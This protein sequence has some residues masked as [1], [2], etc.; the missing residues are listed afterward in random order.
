MLGNF[1]YYKEPQNKINK[2]YM[3]SCMAGA[4]MTFSEFG[5][6]QASDYRTA[7]L[8]MKAGSFWT[9]SLPFL[10]HF[11]LVFTGKWRTIKR[12][13]LYIT[14]IYLPA[15][16]IALIDL[17]TNWL[18][19]GMEYK[20][21]GWRYVVAESPVTYVVYLWVVV[22]LLLSMSLCVRYYFQ[23]TDFIQKKRAKYVL[24][25]FSFY[26][27]SSLVTDSVFPALNI[28][29]PE[30]TSLAFLAEAAFIGYAVWRYKL[31]VLSPATAAESIVSTMAD[32]L[33]L[34]GPDGTIQRVNRA[35][36]EFLGYREDE[37]IGQ[38]F[39]VVIAQ[40]ESEI[41]KY[42]GAIRNRL[43]YIGYVQDFELRLS[44]VDGA[45]ISVSLSISPVYSEHGDLFGVTYIFRDLTARKKYERRLREAKEA[46]EAANRAKST[47]LAN[48]SHELRT[49]LNAI[50]GYSELLQ[51]EAA[52]CGYGE[53]EPDLEKICLA[54]RHLLALISDILDV[55]KIEAGKMELYLETFEARRL[56]DN[57]VTTVQP[58]VAQNDNVLETRYDDDLGAINADLTK[59]RQILFNL[60]SNAAKF[61]E[62]GTITLTVTREEEGE[63]AQ[64]CFRVADTGIGM[65]AEQIAHL[66]RAFSQGDDSTTRKYGGTGLGLAISYHY[67]QMMGGDIAVES[68][69]GEGSTF[70][71]RLPTKVAAR[72]TLPNVL[73][74]KLPVEN[75]ASAVVTKGTVLVIDDDPL[76][77]DLLRQF[78]SRDGIGV[79]TAAGGK[80]GVR[81]AEEL[82][83][84]VI[85][86]DILMPEMDGWEVLTVLKANPLLS[87]IPVIIVTILDDRKQGFALGA[88]DY[89]LKPIEREQL[90]TLLHKYL[91]GKTTVSTAN[92]ILVVEDDE[93]VCRMFRHVLE[94]EGLPVVEADNG[95][96]ALDRVAERQPSL[97]LLDL[98]M[99]KMDGF[100]FIVELRRNPDWQAIPVIVITAKDLTPEDHR[101]LNGRVEQILEKRAYNRAELLHE[102]GTLVHTH[103]QQ[104]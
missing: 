24:L 2:L 79:H 5:Y 17:F 75:A 56:I 63:S 102:V 101:R 96:V 76:V 85:T 4:Y 71:V 50:I 14:I 57:V 12:K 52:D 48:M 89:L 78:L 84:D 67:C 6:R 42:R 66:F 21:W 55:S 10:L 13:R 91:R 88:A 3:L 74:S 31:F 65:S 104:G 77:R 44:A 36:N 61:T 97:I 22:L 53:L 47:F 73:V 38:P 28:D 98:M 33:F 7:L 69:L 34:L 70:T 62:K 72:P 11:V 45:K 68:T 51:E 94:K 100:Q 103:L 29:F 43:G 59:V 93:M 9:F 37:L 99:P 64:L 26:L 49:P 19:A 1:V 95:L 15:L 40:D 27:I 8:W 32:A 87:N 81:L 86:L 16:V 18:T 46:A 83:P 60:L 58:L 35:A 23:T 39:E 25:G 80:I 54:G 41:S 20:W 90:L 82:Y 30:M 92:P